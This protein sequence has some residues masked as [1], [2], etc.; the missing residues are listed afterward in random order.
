MNTGPIDLDDLQAIAELSLTSWAPLSVGEWYTRDGLLNGSYSFDVPDSDFIE[1]VSPETVLMLIA[2]LRE[3]QA[4]ID[5]ST[6]RW[7]DLNRRIAHLDNNLSVQRAGRTIAT[8]T[9]DRVR[10]VLDEYLDPEDVDI[11]SREDVWRFIRDLRAALK[12]DQS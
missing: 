4:L 12:G 9:V 1:A 11:E 2:E 5:E 7:A 8:A 10:E 6:V 3:A